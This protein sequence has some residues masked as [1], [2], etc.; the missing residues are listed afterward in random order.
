MEVRGGLSR[1]PWQVIERWLVLLVALHS[2]G[3]GTGLLL[4]PVW[5]LTFGGWVE[6]P[7]L[8]FPRQA[9][10]FHFVLAI[11][12]L[13]EYRQTRGVRLLLTAK[14]LAT[15]FLIGATLLTSVPWLVPFAGVA[16]GMMAVAVLWVR[17]MASRS[18]SS[19]S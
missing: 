15:V 1:L 10:V 14:S 19:G 13:L 4:V 18:P 9:G 6:I 11:G 7:P 12:Y 17:R 8:F 5:A 2:F 3:I 16:D